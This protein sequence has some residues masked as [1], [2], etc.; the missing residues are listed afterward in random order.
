[1]T[2]LDD[3]RPI[4]ADSHALEGPEVFEGLAARFGDDAPRVV[5]RDGQGDFI[6]VPNMPKRSRNVAYMALAGTRL[7]YETPLPREHASKPGAGS[8]DD[9]EITDLG[10]GVYA[11]DVVVRTAARWLHHAA[12]SPFEAAQTERPNLVLLCLSLAL[13]WLDIR[14]PRLVGETIF[15][16]GG[17]RR[18]FRGGDVPARPPRPLWWSPQDRGPCAARSPPAVRQCPRLPPASPPG[19]RSVRRPRRPPTSAARGP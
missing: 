15:T 16:S 1:M 11:V 2:L 12:G 17:D 8:I 19:F 3:P 4:S 18:R 7:D 13:L 6:V 5:S 9:P 10:Y 14:V